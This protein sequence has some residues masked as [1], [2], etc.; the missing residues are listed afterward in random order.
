MQSEEMTNDSINTGKCMEWNG[1]YWKCDH[2]AGIF[3]SRMCIFSSV[4]AFFLIYYTV[5]IDPHKNAQPNRERCAC[6]E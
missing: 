2:F 1:K 4:V 6:F 3:E 5:L